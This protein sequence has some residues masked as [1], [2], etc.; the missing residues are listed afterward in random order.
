[1]R[2]PWYRI[3]GYMIYWTVIVMPMLIYMIIKERK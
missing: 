1:M 2:Y 3:L